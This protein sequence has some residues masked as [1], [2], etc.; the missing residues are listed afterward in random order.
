MVVIKI[1]FSHGGRTECT[2]RLETFCIVD[3]LFTVPVQT[4][5]KCHFVHGSC[6]DTRIDDAILGSVLVMHAN[7]HARVR[8]DTLDT[9]LRRVTHTSWGGRLPRALLH[10]VD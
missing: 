10:L 7:T 8:S 4:S 1:V 3:L 9:K 2:S 6:I 5:E